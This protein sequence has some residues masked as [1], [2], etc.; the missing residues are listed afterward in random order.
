MGYDF[1]ELQILSDMNEDTLINVQDIVL[2]A[3]LILE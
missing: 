2:L 1:T 3:N